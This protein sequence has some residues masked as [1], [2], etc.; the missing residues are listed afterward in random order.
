M[1]PV[2]GRLSDSIG[3]R[4]I[5]LVCTLLVLLT[6]YPTLAWLVQHP[7]FHRLLIVELWFSVLYGSYNGAMVVYLTEIMPPAVRSTGFSLA[8]S[9]ATA[10]FGGYTPAICTYL[11]HV[12]SNKAMPGVWL[13]VAAVC[14]LAAIIATAQMNSIPKERIR[15]GGDHHGNDVAVL[16]VGDA[17][18]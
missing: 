11:I 6:A 17:A 9:L 1:L 14:A 7:S 2:K 4:P 3:R 18:P 8:Y 15:S 12:T 5:L 16:N 10:I 13:C